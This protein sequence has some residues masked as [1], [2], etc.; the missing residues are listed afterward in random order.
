MTIFYDPDN[1]SSWEGDVLEVV[2]PALLNEQEIPDYVAA[3]TIAQTRFD[4]INQE[5]EVIFQDTRKNILVEGCTA[6]RKD[7]GRRV[8][9]IFQRWSDNR[10]TIIV[11][12]ESGGED[13]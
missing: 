2:E 3:E 7:N 5:L 9:L 8:K 13:D 10:I 11:N 6:L 1:I 4:F 12:G